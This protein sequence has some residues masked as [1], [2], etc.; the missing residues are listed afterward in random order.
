[1]CF[2]TLLKQPDSGGERKSHQKAE[3]KY[4]KENYEHSQHKI[5]ADE[6]RAEERNEKKI[7]SNEQRTKEK[8][9][10]KILFQILAKNSLGEEASHS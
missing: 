7:G 2:F 6:A 1:M 10:S 5:E 3:R 9:F 8:S 4:E